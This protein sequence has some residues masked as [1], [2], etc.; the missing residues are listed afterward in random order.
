MKTFLMVFFICLAMGCRGQLKAAG[1]E[2]IQPGDTLTIG[3]TNKLIS[4]KKL[5]AD[6]QIYY[7]KNCLIRYYKTRQVGTLFGIASV[8]A[9]AAY[10]ID[11]SKKTETLVISGAF[12]LA[13][14]ITHLS[15]EKWLKRA[16]IKPS[17]AGFGVKFQF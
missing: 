15:A 12:G 9:A 7:M 14:V 17:D 4:G 1:G 16:S 3:M 11:D 10:T 13:S 8:A 5:N 2:T 6:D